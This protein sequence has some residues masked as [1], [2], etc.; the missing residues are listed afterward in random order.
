M[1]EDMFK[2]IVE[3]PR[4]GWRTRRHKRGQYSN[5]SDLPAKIGMKRHV[6]VMGIKSKWL[7]ENLQPLKRYLGQQV[8]RPWSEVYSEIS[9]HLAPGHTVKEH[10]RGHIG[11]FVARIAIGRNGEWIAAEHL[12]GVT[13]TNWHQP[14][15]IDPI[16]SLLKDSSKLWKKL[17]VD[18]FPWKRGKP[19]PDPNVFMPPKGREFR[20]IGGIWYA[21]GFHVEPEAAAWVFD[22]IERKLVPAAKRHAVSKRQISGAELKAF[23]LSNTHI[24]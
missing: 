8:G 7:N 1:R 24:N 9:A 15:Y 3:R 14:Y 13:S 21:I 20:R 10:V 2:I 5:E 11:D 17:G 12:F 23:G 16:D 18:P 22:L 6:A 19:K 4:G